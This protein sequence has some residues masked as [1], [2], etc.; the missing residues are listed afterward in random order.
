[1]KVQ[2]GSEAG[3]RT[4]VRSVFDQFDVDNSNSIDA[5][6]FRSLCIELGYYFSADEV[7]SRKLTSHVLGLLLTLSGFVVSHCVCYH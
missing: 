3:L 2:V 7:R 1:M 4:F 6:E 5:E